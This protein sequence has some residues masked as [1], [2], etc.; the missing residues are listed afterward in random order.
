MSEYILFLNLKQTNVR[1]KYLYWKLYDYFNILEYSSSFYSFYTLTHLRTNVQIYSYKQI[2]H[3]RMFECNYL[4]PIYSNISECIQDVCIYIYMILDPDAY[5]S[6]Y[7][8]TNRQADPWYMCLVSVWC[9]H[10]GSYCRKM[11]FYL[12]FIS[13]IVS[14]FDWITSLQFSAAGSDKMPSR[15]KWRQRSWSG[16]WKLYL[17]KLRNVFVLNCKN[18]FVWIVKCICPNCKLHL[19][20]RWKWKERCWSE[21]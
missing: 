6:I 14:Q 7:L 13:E 19:F 21:M 12:H 5:V 10:L 15:R 20:S 1:M 8:R 2:W 17:S 16:K 3:K 11:Y 18:T 4:W 9:I